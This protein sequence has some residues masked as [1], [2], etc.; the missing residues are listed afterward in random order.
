MLTAGI[1]KIRIQGDK[2]KKWGHICKSVFRMLYSPSKPRNN[3]LRIET[4]HDQ[5]TYG[6][7]KNDLISRNKMRHI[8]TV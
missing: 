2:V 1:R 6:G 8:F 4:V 3:P 5:I 7:T